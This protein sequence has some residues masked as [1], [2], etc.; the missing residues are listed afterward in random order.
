MARPPGAVE[1][2]T[3]S[4]EW[5]EGD[6]VTDDPEDDDPVTDPEAEPEEGAFG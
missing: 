1:V 6:P 2:V 3:V 4:D 5:D